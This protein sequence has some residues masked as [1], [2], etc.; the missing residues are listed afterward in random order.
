MPEP[1]RKDKVKALLLMADGAAAAAREG[2]I[3]MALT[4]LDC[5]RIALFDVLEVEPGG[6]MEITPEVHEAILHF[7][8]IAL[9]RAKEAYHD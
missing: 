8:R 2:R 7:Q 5:I 1:L 3:G 4:G 9:Q 6:S